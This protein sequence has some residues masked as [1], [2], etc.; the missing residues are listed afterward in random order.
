MP[1]GEAARLG[2]AATDAGTI[3]ARL[4]DGGEVALI[5]PASGG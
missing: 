3:G 5:T 1:N 2:E 4:H